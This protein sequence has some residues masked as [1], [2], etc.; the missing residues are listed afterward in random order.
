MSTSTE[1]TTFKG[2]SFTPLAE[3][4]P[5]DLPELQIVSREGRDWK[6]ITGN[7]AVCLCCTLSVAIPVVL[8]AAVI[9]GTVS[10]RYVPDEDWKW[11]PDPLC[12]KI[13]YNLQPEFYIKHCRPEK[14]IHDDQDRVTCYVLT[15]VMGTFFSVVISL[16]ACVGLGVATAE[17]LSC[18]ESDGEEVVSESETVTESETESE[19]EVKVVHVDPPLEHNSDDPKNTVIVLN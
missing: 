7:A 14:D 19:E 6:N 10:C 16:V 9:I 8:I 17:V 11:E 18:L 13:D 12:P 1:L 15:S 2:V 3:N 5:N 4:E